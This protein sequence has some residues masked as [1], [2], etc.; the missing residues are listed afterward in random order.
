MQATSCNIPS[1][2][3]PSIASLTLSPWTAMAHGHLASFPSQCRQGSIA[4]R[5]RGD[6]VP[7]D[8]HAAPADDWRSRKERPDTPGRMQCPGCSWVPWTNETLPLEELQMGS[9]STS[10]RLLKLGLDPILTVKIIC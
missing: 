7:P 10:F 1:L 6:I 2:H 3:G 4:Q 8:P 9:S 5:I